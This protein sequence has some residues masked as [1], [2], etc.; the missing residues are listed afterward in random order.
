MELVGS[1][2]SKHAADNAF[3]QAGFEECA[4]RDLVGVV[5]LHD[6]FAANEVFY[7]LHSPWTFIDILTVN[8]LPGAGT[9]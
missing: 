5:E 3:A 8:H 2:M 9:V 4:S 7:T 1:S 6:C